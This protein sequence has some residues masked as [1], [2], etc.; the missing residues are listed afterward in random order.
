MWGDPLDPAIGCGVLAETHFALLIG[1]ARL[2][3]DRLELG[4]GGDNLIRRICFVVAALLASACEHAPARPPETNGSSL[5]REILANPARS[6]GRKVEFEVGIAAGDM[7]KRGGGTDVFG[8]IIWSETH[9][10]T[11]APD[12]AVGPTCIFAIADFAGMPTL[13]VQPVVVDGRSPCFPYATPLAKK[14]TGTVTGFR[15]IKL[16]LDN[17]LTA[18][19]APVLADASFGLSAFDEAP[20]IQLSPEYLKTL[21]QQSPPR[22]PPSALPAPGAAVPSSCH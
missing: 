14:L 21:E 3:R 2:Q 5:H 17:R 18:F 15:D 16:C 11:P 6:V 8:G 9:S 1:G 20:K 7:L 13:P 19:R 12:F 10:L 22:P 4:Y